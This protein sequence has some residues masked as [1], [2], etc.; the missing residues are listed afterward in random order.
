MSFENFEARIKGFGT[1]CKL[2]DNI[3]SECIL[4]ELSAKELALSSKLSKYF[5]TFSHDDQL[6]KIHCLDKWGNDSKII[7]KFKYRGSWL[8]SYLFQGEEEQEIVYQPLHFPD[9]TSHYL[10]AK[11]CRCNMYLGN[12]ILPSPPSSKIPKIPVVENLTKERFD[13]LFDA[14]AIPVLIKNCGV[15]KWKAWND[16]K[17]ENLLEKYG[18]SVFRVANDHGGKNGYLPMTLESYVRY[19]KLQRDETPLYIFDPNFIDRHPE[20]AED[21]EIP[22]YFQEDFFEVLAD[23]RPPYRWIIIGP[24]RSGASWH[25]DPTGTSAWNT[26]LSGRKRWALYPPHIF[27]PGLTI[28]RH[29]HGHH[30]VLL[31]NEENYEKYSTTSLFWYLEVYPQLLLDSNLPLEIIQEPGQTIF[32]PSGWWHM[33]LNLEDTIA[34]TQNFA[35]INNLENVCKELIDEKHYRAWENFHQNL[36]KIHPYLESFISQKILLFSDTMNDPIIPEEGFSS[37]T[38]FIESFHNLDLWHPR[39]L[40]ALE[41]CGLNLNENDEIDVIFSGQNP[42][43]RTSTT[44]IKFYSHLFNGINTWTTEI[45]AYS[46]INKQ[47]SKE[48]VNYFPKLLGSG[49]LFD[50]DDGSSEKKYRWPFLIINAISENVLSLFEVNNNNSNIN[51]NEDYIN[52][53]NEDYNNIND[54]FNDKDYEIQINW[55][56]LIDLITRILL[57]LHCLSITTTTT[58]T[59]S[60]IISSTTTT[61]SS[62]ISSTTTTP[63]P[64]T[65]TP[66]PMTTQ[67][68]S[69]P[70]RRIIQNDHPF[71]KFLSQRLEKSYNFHSRLLIFPLHL[72][73]Q[74]ISYLP[75]S[76]WEIYNPELDSE[77]GFLHGDLNAEN[78][79]GLIIS[80]NDNNNDDDDNNDDN[81]NNEDDNNNDDDDNDNSNSNGDDDIQSGIWKTSTIIDFGDCQLYGGDPLFDLIPFFISVL[82]CS[83]TLLKK[84]IKKY[85]NINYINSNNSNDSND[86]I[87]NSN[88]DINDNINNSNDSNNS[89]DNF[90]NSNYKPK[91]STRNFKRRAMWYTLLWEFEGATKYLIKRLPEIRELKNWYEVEDLVWNID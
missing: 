48:L 86:N 3:I 6:W 1:L 19:I 77:A 64:M 25:V 37:R 83:K 49:Y 18:Q 59:Q 46:L 58:T 12:F 84:F 56:E 24:A 11:W 55:E 53:D 45:T 4:S 66:S 74:L 43:F 68:T 73:S 8:L 80:D 91:M 76:V 30:Q 9:I 61:Q 44:I 71:H 29:H 85:N 78:I 79:L 34:V 51:N 75:N 42:V 70:P 82:G 40:K 38:D 60:S 22:K 28:S 10:Y 41:L 27:P 67:S 7:K 31:Y 14:Q 23:K 50:D 13:A 69:S 52:N 17:W 57:E 47:I 5:Y 62:I 72:I 2:P 63:S 54:Y 39:V 36:I 32:V 33:V 15:E 21:Y 87:N 16:W 81:D 26:L 20:M 88:D 90:N 89:N 35:N 65:T